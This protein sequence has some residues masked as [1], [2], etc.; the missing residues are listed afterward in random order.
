VTH[1]SGHASSLA[2]D[3]GG[4]SFDALLRAAAQISEGGTAGKARLALGSTLA[5]GRLQILRRLGSGGMGVVFEAFDA[6][7]RSKVA[8]KVLTDVRPDRV[9]RVKNEFRALLDV[10]NESLLRLYDLF[11]DEG[12]WYYTMELVSGVPFDLYVQGDEARLRSCLAQLGSAV[13]AMH[14]AGKLH[15]DLKPSNVLVTEEG[16]L[17]VLDFGLSIDAAAGGIG[18]TLSEQQAVCGTPAYMAPEQ[19]AG[20]PPLPASDLYAIGVML[21]EALTGGLPFEGHGGAIVA[22]KQRDAAP[23]LPDGLAIPDDLRRLCHTLLARDPGERPTAAELALQLGVEV[24]DAPSQHGAGSRAVSRL[25]GRERELAQLE[26]AFADT[27]RGEA[28]V[29]RVT[30]ESGLG[31][32]ALCASFV[33][34]LRARND[35]MVLDGRCYERESV[36]F[37]AFDPLIDSLTR[38]LRRLSS[39]ELARFLPEDAASLVRLFPVLERMP[40]FAQATPLDAP[41]SE[42]LQQRAFTALGTCLHSCA[43]AVR[44][45]SSWTTCSGRTPTRSCSCRHC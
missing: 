28:V 24:S 16:R 13:W 5:G 6:E 4:Q 1:E 36:P 34:R 37:K 45:C 41:S 7:R 43:R 9:Y 19:A 18:Q 25:F 30:G 11:S 35:V 40:A 33:A 44:W 39:E 15:R 20:D 22:A 17:V 14:D 23:V 21:F 2:D 42:A 29:V 38:L 31:K 26:Q 10:R 12:L 3:T 27:L 32:S 8:L